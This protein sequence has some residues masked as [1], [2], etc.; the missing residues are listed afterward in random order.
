MRRLRLSRRG[1]DGRYLERMHVAFLV[2]NG[3][4]FAG[5]KC[6]RA[7]AVPAFIVIFRS[8]I[9]I[10]YP[11]PVLG[12]SGAMDEKAVLI[13]FAF[14]ES[15]DAAGIAVLLPERGNIVVFDQ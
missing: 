4:V 13:R 11:A 9:V 10:E 7:E 15:S 1:L 8:F 12:P 5:A 3:D 14:P 6:M 2:A